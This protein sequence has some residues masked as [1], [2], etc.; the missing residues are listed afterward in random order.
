MKTIFTMGFGT[1]YSLFGSPFSMGQQTGTMTAASLDYAVS[2]FNQTSTWV[3]NNSNQQYWLGSDYPTFQQQWA[4]AYQLSG[5]VLGY[6]SIL[7]SG[8]TLSDDQNTKAL[9]FANAISFAWGIIQQHPSP[10]GA[11]PGAA[12]PAAA[13]PAPVTTPAPVPAAPQTPAQQVTQA[14]AGTAAG[15][16]AATAAKAAAKAPVPTPPRPGVQVP[17]S[18]GPNPLVIGGV[19]IAGLAILAFALK[20]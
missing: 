12:A 7:D 3:N 13:A 9:Q 18:P 17:P 20:K 11:A 1:Q 2:L 8:G 14:A 10:A 16:T 5:D 19:A 6:D 15:I 4:L